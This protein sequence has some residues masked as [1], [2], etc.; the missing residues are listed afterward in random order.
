[1]N[2]KISNAREQQQTTHRR[3]DDAHECPATIAVGH[4]DA[5]DEE[6][7]H[8]AAHDA[9]DGDGRLDEAAEALGEEGHADHDGAHYQG[10]GVV[11]EMMLMII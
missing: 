2:R 11:I 6:A 9:G 10:C 5:Q 4:E 8:R 1:M 3:R 7:E